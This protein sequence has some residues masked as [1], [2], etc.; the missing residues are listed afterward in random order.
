MSSVRVISI[1]NYTNITT[2]WRKI[3]WTELSNTYRLNGNVPNIYIL[4]VGN[5]YFIVKGKKVN[6]SL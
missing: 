4:H 3:F 2:S 6:L 5:K 1:E